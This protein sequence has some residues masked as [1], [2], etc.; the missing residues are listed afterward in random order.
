[1]DDL[2]LPTLRSIPFIGK[3]T[4]KEPDVRSILRTFEVMSMGLSYSAP[5]GPTHYMFGLFG[6][7]RKYYWE[8]HSDCEAFSL[9]KGSHRC[10]WISQAQD[11]SGERKPGGLLGVVC[12]PVTHTVIRIARCSG[13][14][15]HRVVP[16]PVPRPVSNCVGTPHEITTECL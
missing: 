10:K 15:V 5:P 1:M 3:D 12:C 13:T 4:V 14:Q 2:R 6:K 9:G 11:V 16:F 8:P 7:N